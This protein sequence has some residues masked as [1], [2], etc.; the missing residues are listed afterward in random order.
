MVLFV[1]E[2]CYCWFR[3]GRLIDP[4]LMMNIYNR[5]QLEVGSQGGDESENRYHVCS[6]PRRSL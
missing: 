1:S 3:S 2:A 6:D 4:T 5:N